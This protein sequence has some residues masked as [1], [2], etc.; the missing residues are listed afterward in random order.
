MRHSVQ[1]P[2]EVPAWAQQ[3]WAPPPFLNLVY[4]DEED[5]DAGN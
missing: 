4:D 2:L 5:I 1:P 3:L